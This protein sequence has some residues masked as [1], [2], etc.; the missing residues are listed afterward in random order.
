MKNFPLLIILL[1]VCHVIF[2]QTYT[3]PGA[4]VQ[5]Q[6]V[7]P[8]WFE[9]GDGQKDTL[10]YCYD[11]NAIDGGF[12][13]G[14]SAYGEKLLSI[15]PSKFNV[16]YSNP[17]NTDTMLVKAYTTSYLQSGGSIFTLN[18]IM[19]L[20][21]RWDPLIF[22]S[23]SLPFPDIAP[24]PRAEGRMFFDLPTHVD[25]CEYSAPILMT[26]TASVLYFQCYKPDS[27]V[28]TGPALSYLAFSVHPW[29][30]QYTGITQ[31]STVNADIVVFPNPATD[32][33]NIVTSKKFEHMIWRLMDI[34]GLVLCGGETNEQRIEV[35]IATY[36]PGPYLLS[37][38]ADDC[39]QSFIIIKQ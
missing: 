37:I 21:L 19:P 13:P 5:P 36:R 1:L 33:L 28:F 2:A 34:T 18:I 17:Y 7:M 12:W 9:N 38:L 4:Q 16:F 27:I 26:D 22:Y 35:S 25:N 20:T 30:G 29:V 32:K 23:D 24:A 14:D 3:V 8:L 39:S 31:A 15:N 11:E 6:W 10:Y